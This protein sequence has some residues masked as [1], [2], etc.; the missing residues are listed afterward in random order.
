MR[1]FTIGIGNGIS[2]ALI[3]GVAMAGRGDYE[4]VKDQENIEEKTQYLISSA[5]TPVL[6]DIK[7]TFDQ[8]DMVSQT[9]P[10]T[11]TQQ[12]G[13]IKKNERFQMLVFL[14]KNFTQN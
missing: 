5:I 2:P 11:Q 4:Y 9:I 1:F 7:I 6:T 12:I 14:N 10:E 13:F 3:Q 8:P